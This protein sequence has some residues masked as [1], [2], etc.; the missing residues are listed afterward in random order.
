MPSSF[1]AAAYLPDEG[2]TEVFTSHDNRVTM[3]GQFFPNGQGAVVDGGTTT[4]GRS[5]G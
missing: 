1:A 5:P 3:G 2:F 4:K